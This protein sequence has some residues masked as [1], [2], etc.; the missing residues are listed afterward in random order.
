MERKKQRKEENN[1]PAGKEEEGEGQ[2]ELEKIRETR[3]LTGQERRKDE[4]K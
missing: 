3:N 1:S 4:G 2:V